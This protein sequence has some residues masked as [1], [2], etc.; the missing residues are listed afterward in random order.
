M[1]LRLDKIFFNHPDTAR[2]GA[3]TIRQ[4]ETKYV[5]LP[6]WQFNGVAPNPTPVAYRCDKV[7][8][9]IIIKASFHRDDDDRN[10]LEI[11]AVSPVGDHLGNVSARTVTF[12]ANGDS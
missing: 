6:E 5:P 8:T 2:T 12:N 9:K 4:N 1:T 7:P 10:D 11:Q 3:I